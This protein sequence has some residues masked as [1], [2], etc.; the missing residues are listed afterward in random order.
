MSLLSH[1]TRILLSEDDWSSASTLAW[2]NYIYIENCMRNCYLT[3][4]IFL[5]VDEKE[6]ALLCNWLEIFRLSISAWNTK[7]QNLYQDSLCILYRVFLKICWLGNLINVVI[8]LFVCFIILVILFQS[9]LHFQT[10]VYFRVVRS[11]FHYFYY[12]IPFSTKLLNKN[13]IQICKF[14]NSGSSNYHSDQNSLYSCL[15]S[16]NKF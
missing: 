9:I 15:L 10:W 6:V 11:I 16:A 1:C 7:E 12:V 4:I 3:H 14:H 8:I 5:Y 13:I 2:N